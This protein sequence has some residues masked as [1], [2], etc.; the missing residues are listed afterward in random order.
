MGFKAH[1]KS[2]VGK[3][4]YNVLVLLTDGTIHDMPETIEHVVDLA[5]FP[6]S[7]IIIGVGDANFDAMKALDGDEHG[8]KDRKGRS[9]A[10]DIVQFV[11]FRE[12]VGKGD[13]AEQVLAEI[14]T[15]FVSYMEK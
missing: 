12:A 9:A 2:S 1:C 11:E 3:P 5:E 15:Q 10:R 6:C 8:L 4:V 14:P 7:I 13:L